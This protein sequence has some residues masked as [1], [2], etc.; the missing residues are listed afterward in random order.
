MEGP[1]IKEVP[2]RRKVLQEKKKKIEKELE[3]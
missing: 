1:T 3:K 2:T